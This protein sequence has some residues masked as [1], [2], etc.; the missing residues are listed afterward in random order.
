MLDNTT[1]AVLV[2]LPRTAGEATFAKEQARG[3]T[4]SMANGEGLLSPLLRNES[5]YPTLNA[6]VVNDV[7]LSSIGR[8]RRLP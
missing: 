7:V 6:F 8:V 4:H 1:I 3:N 2:R 5:M